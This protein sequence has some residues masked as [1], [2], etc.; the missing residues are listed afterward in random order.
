MEIVKAADNGVVTL[1][2]NGRVDTN[3]APA[4]EKELRG[5]I[6]TAEKLVL[7]LGEV[8]YVSSAGLRAFLVGCKEAQKAKKTIV[9]RN[10]KPEVMEVFKMTGFDK[11]FAFE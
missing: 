2:V 4:L 10:V 3:T 11:L 8:G 9:L 1:G 7:D 5:E 6:A